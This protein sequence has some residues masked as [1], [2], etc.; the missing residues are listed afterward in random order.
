MGKQLEDINM[1]LKRSAMVGREVEEA[2]S[3]DLSTVAMWTIGTIAASVLA[4]CYTIPP[5]ILTALGCGLAG[6]S[7]SN[8]SNDPLTAFV[9]VFIPAFLFWPWLLLG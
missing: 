1:R 9:V 8:C 2:E 3:W 6:S 5:I 7:S 4:I